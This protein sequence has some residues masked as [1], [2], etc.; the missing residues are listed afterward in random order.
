MSGLSEDWVGIVVGGF[1]RRAGRKLEG[2]IGPKGR[3]Y[4]IIY[5]RWRKFDIEEVELEEGEEGDYHIG[6]ASILR[7]VLR[8][9]GYRGWIEW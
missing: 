4:E 2:M 8:T 6:E 3:E 5:N 9:D 1:Q 7:K